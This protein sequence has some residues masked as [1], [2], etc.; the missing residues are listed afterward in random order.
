M[1]AEVCYAVK[2]KSIWWCASDNIAGIK[3]NIKANRS[4]Y[5]HFCHKFSVLLLLIKSEY[6]NISTANLLFV[7]IL[8]KYNERLK[9]FDTTAVTLKIL[10]TGLNGNNLKHV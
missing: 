3:S 7:P 8:A 2:I 9:H 6:Y 10:Y 5:E 1:K 4:N